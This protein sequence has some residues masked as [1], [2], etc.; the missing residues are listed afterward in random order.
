MQQAARFLGL[1]LEDKA[2][3]LSCAWR[4]ISTYLALKT[5]G[6]P[7]VSRDLSDELT[8]S[9]RKSSGTLSAAKIIWAVRAAARALPWTK[10]LAQAVTLHFLLARSGHASIVRIGI[11]GDQKLG[12]KAHAW[13]VH[14]ERIVIG[15]A[16]AADGRFRPMTDLQLATQ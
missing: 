9:R 4:L 8:R 5:L 16:G 12:F 3:L 1:P 11:A 7:R 2:L 14:K 13:V 6:Y 10:C 15:E